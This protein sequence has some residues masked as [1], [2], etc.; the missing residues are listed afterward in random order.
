ML[1]IA[2]L[3]FLELFSRVTPEKAVSIFI[4][5][6]L[7]FSVHFGTHS[8]HRSRLGLFWGA[9]AILGT[10]LPGFSLTFYS[11]SFTQNTHVKTHFL[12]HM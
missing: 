6:M 4:R 12:T 5:K 7:I 9:V 1:R 2:P 10:L 3:L 8:S 11:P